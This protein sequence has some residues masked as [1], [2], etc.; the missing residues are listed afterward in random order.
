VVHPQSTR[1]CDGGWG[2][3]TDSHN[4]HAANRVRSV[5]VTGRSHLSVV[6]SPR[7]RAGAVRDAAAA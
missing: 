4:A 2:T 3:D 5:P 6:R 1:G 7:V